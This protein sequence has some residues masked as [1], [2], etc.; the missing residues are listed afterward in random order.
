MIAFK[1]PL[2]HTTPT[3]DVKNDARRCASSSPERRDMEYKE[4]KV[5]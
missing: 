3:T 2:D 4:Y 5:T 1:T